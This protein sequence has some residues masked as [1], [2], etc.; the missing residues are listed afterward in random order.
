MNITSELVAAAVPVTILRLDGDLDASSYEELIDAGRSSVA[1]GARYIL[2]DMRRVPFMGSSGL[3]AILPVHGRIEHTNA[4]AFRTAL[5][6]AVNAQL[7]AGATGLV[8]DLSGTE[9]MSSAGLR[10]LM[11]ANNAAKGRGARIAVGG[12]RAVLAEIFAISRF[13]MVFPCHATVAEATASL[14]G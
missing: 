10:V 5:L 14:G 12:L 4:D 8:L 7:E 13:N 2:I 6:A 11:L 9:Y 1:D 3:V